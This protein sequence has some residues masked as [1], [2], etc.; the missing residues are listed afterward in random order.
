MKVKPMYF[1]L[2]LSIGIYIGALA[3]WYYDKNNDLPPDPKIIEY[4]ESVK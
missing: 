4:L 2:V 1:W 3:R